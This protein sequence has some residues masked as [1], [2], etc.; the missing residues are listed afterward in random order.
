MVFGTHFACGR[1]PTPKAFHSAAQ[2]RA[3]QAWVHDTSNLFT[4]KG[5]A[6]KDFCSRI[7]ENSGDSLEFTL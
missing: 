6:V 3:A 2:G 7:R 4:P 5:N 1:Q